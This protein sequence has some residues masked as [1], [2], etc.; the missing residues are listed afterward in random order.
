M[1]NNDTTN[2]NNM[3]IDNF[4]TALESCAESSSNKLFDD[5]SNNSAS[6]GSVNK[7]LL[8]ENEKREDRFNSE[9]DGFNNNNAEELIICYDT[10]NASKY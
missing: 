9:S 1:S 10:I 7:E 8:K 2:A 6:I 3:S 4:N 5:V